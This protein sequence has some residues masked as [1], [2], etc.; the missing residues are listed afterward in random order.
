MVVEGEPGVIQLVVGPTADLW[1]VVAQTGS[2]VVHVCHAD[3]R[4]LAEVFA[5]LRPNP[6]GIFAGLASTESDHGPV[7]DRLANRAF[8]RFLD[9]TESGYSGVVRGEVE[10]IEAAAITDP[11]VYFRG[12]YHS[13]G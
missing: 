3:D 4:H 12:G 5:G 2:F 7:I 8:C 11:L 6:G 10:R 13:L 9:R 1:D